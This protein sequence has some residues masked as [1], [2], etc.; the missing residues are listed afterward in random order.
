[1]AHGRTVA[2]DLN[3]PLEDLRL[4]YRRDHR[5]QI[6]RARKAGLDVVV[7]DWSRMGE[8]ISIYHATME[9]VGAADSYFFPARY[10][11]QLRSR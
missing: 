11:E 9:R 8:F 1:M 3:R 2:L 4:S 7:D 5:N 10:F 6:R